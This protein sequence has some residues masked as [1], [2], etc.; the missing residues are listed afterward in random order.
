MAAVSD[1]GLQFQIDAPDPTLDFSGENKGDLSYY[2]TYMRDSYSRATSN[3]RAILNTLKNS[4]EGQEN[5]AT[6]ETPNQDAAARSA[7]GN[8]NL[9]AMLGSVSHPVTDDREKKEK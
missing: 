4:L 3:F 9:Q 8:T 1:G 2:E 5:N 6:I 7:L